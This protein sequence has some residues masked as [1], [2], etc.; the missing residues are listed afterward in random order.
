MIAGH[1]FKCLWHPGRDIKAD[2]RWAIRTESIAAAG[3]W[4]TSFSEEDC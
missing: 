2:S 3:T 1:K 4:G